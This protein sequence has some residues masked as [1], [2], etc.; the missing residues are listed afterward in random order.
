MKIKKYIQKYIYKKAKR[1][2]PEAKF[3]VEK[4]VSNTLRVDYVKNI[5]N[6]SKIFF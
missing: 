6:N 3:I 2:N 1:I 4:T 5:F